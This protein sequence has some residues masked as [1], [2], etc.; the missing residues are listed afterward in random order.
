MTSMI[1]PETLAQVATDAELIA[2]LDKHADHDDTVGAILAELDNRDA[3]ELAAEEVDEQ[4]RL[5]DMVRQQR[6]AGESLEQTVDRMY[7]EHTAERHDQAENATRGHM[8]N[9]KGLAKGVDPY[10][11]FHGPAS[12]AAMYASEELMG[13]WKANGRMPWIAYMAMML[14]RP[15]DIRKAREVMRRAADFGL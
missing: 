3:D 6:R 7:G 2:L 13:W 8:L 12:R 9:R 10:S 1:S 5:A 15:S 14:G 11:L 4:T